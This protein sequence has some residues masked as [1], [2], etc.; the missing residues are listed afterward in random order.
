[1]YIPDG[2]LSPSTCASLYAASSPFWYI[3]LRHVRQVL[4]SRTHSVA[5]HLRGIS[6][7][8]MMF[9]LP[10]P[11]GT[12]C[13]AVGMAMAAITLRPWISIVSISL[14]LLVQ[15]LLFGDGAMTAYGAN[16]FNMG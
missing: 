12:T 3:A 16:C 14:V 9:N 11:G 6:F 4:S 10:L 2:Y 1:M 15:A 5:V 7:V 8:V 13:H